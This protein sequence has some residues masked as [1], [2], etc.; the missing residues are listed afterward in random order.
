[1]DIRRAMNQPRHLESLVAA[2]M[3]ATFTGVCNPYAG[4]D[5]TLEHAD[6][7]AARLNNLCCYLNGCAHARIALMSGP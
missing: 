4:Y 5:P 3:G 7:A 6:A 2:L 1:M